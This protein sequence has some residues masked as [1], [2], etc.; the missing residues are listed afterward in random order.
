MQKL[1][2]AWLQPQVPLD[3]PAAPEWHLTKLT[4]Q[5]TNAGTGTSKQVP[6]TQIV[7]L[8]TVVHGC[9]AKMRPKYSFPTLEQAD[10]FRTAIELIEQGKSMDQ[11]V[12]PQPEDADDD[13]ADLDDD[14]MDED[15]EELV[16]DA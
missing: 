15:I 16:L 2:V 14:D 13:T 5:M 12:G 8:K 11:N 6:W 10:F 3:N 1:L 7:D 4:T 9:T